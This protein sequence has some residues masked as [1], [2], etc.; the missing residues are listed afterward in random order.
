[1]PRH[2]GPELSAQEIVDHA[3]AGIAVMALDGRFLRVNPAMC[4]LLERSEAELLTLTAGDVVDPAGRPRPRVRQTVLA[5]GRVTVDRLFVSASG[6]AFWASLAAALVRADDGEPRAVVI[7]VTDV[8]E[9]KRIEDDLRH[10]A[11]HDALTGL[12][13]RRRFELDLAHQVELCRRYSESA[14]VVML[15]LDHLKR[16][17]DTHG[18]PA[19]DAL[20]VAVARILEGRLRASDTLARLGGDEFA[21]ILPHVRRAAALKLA[22]SLVVAIAEE[23]PHGC[24]ASAGVVVIDRDAPGAA[25]VLAVADRAMYE[26]KRGGRGRATL[27]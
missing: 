17:N 7:Q 13:N 8:S 19:G 18:H 4:E 11:D 20:L 12:L 26:A 22:E 16:V 5:Q 10:A 15:D 21:A 1:M 25:E 23:A 6:R 24:T 14:A 3:P 9:R 27:A 2:A